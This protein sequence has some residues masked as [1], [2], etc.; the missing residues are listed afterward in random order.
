MSHISKIELEVKELGCLKQACNRLGLTMIDPEALKKHVTRLDKE[1]FQ[2]HFHA[3]GDA[4]IRHCLDAIDA[5]RRGGHRDAHR[6]PYLS[7]DRHHG[8]SE[9]RRPVGDCAADGG[10]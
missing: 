2:V 5:A 8:L 6:M 4:A 1:G 3:I 10:A 9:K 7:R